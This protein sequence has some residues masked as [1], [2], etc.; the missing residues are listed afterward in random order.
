MHGEVRLQDLTRAAVSD[1]RKQP[2]MH[3]VTRSVRDELASATIRALSEMHTPYAA[4]SPARE[5]MA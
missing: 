2:I 4:L 1:P 5:P 3:C